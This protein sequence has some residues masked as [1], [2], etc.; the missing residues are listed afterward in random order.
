MPTPYERAA[1]LLDVRNLSSDQ[2][3][4]V[5]SF[6]R[7]YQPGGW[8]YAIHQGSTSLVKLGRSEHV[9]RR[10]NALSRQHRTPLTLLASAYCPCSVAAVEVWLHRHFH[11]VRVAGEWFACDPGLFTELSTFTNVVQDAHHE[12]LCQTWHDFIVRKLVGSWV[13]DR[14]RV[15]L[16][17]SSGTIA[18]NAWAGN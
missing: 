4:I 10:L 6:I 17:I 14:E 2:V 7:Q 15:R 11:S 12:I 18:V 13:L 1:K 9:Q 8:V 16:F 5:I 3:A